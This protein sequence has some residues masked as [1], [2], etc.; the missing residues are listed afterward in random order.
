[1]Y[2]LK[3]IGKARVMTKRSVGSIMNEKEILS[4]FL[5]EPSNFIVNMHCAF[6]DRE[7]LYLLLDYMDAGDLRYYINRRVEFS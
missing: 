1:M 3:V 7:N 2:A 5:N 6:Q 4:S